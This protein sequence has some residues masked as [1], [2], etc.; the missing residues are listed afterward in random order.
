MTTYRVTER[1][2]VVYTWT[3]DSDEV[4]FNGDDL[5]EELRAINGVPDYARS[6]LVESE[7]THEVVQEDGTPIPTEG[8]PA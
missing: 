4:E 2:V 6:H 5:E 7:T 3:V 8:A 1:Q